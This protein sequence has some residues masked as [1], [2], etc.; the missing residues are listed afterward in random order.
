MSDRQGAFISSG[1]SKDDYRMYKR[2]ISEESS[3]EISQT[4]QT[5]QIVTTNKK[6]IDEFTND[7]DDISS[8]F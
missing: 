5:S 4:E 3:P 8:S 2:D 6:K 1:N 7:N